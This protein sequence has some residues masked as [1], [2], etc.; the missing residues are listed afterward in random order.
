MSIDK[1][2]L[3][4]GDSV[5]IQTSFEIFKYLIKKKNPIYLWQED[6]DV[7]PTCDQKLIWTDM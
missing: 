5:S 6:Y 2:E 3:F 7:I 1:L 4:P